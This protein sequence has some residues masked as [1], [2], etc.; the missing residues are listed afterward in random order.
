MLDSFI[1]ESMRTNCL[2][3]SK[4]LFTLALCD[5]N[6]FIPTHA[7]NIKYHIDGWRLKISCF[8][9]VT[10]FQ[11]V[12]G[13][14]F[15]KS[16]SCKTKFNFPIRPILTAFVF[17]SCHEQNR[18]KRHIM[19]RNRLS[20]EAKNNYGELCFHC[21]VIDSLMALTS[22]G[23]FLKFIAQPRKHISP[24]RHFAC[25]EVKAIISHLLVNYD[26][27]LADKSPLPPMTWRTTQIPKP[28]TSL[29][30]RPRQDLYFRFA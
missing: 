5:Y 17:S 13:F 28:K 15:I 11:R 6:E 20:G 18:G 26:I 7:P 4:Y 29:L 21:L 3:A 2:D 22:P 23:F 1:K 30:I 16:Q 27:E 12:T 8:W 14:V 10:R 25:L 24:G 19:M 9:M